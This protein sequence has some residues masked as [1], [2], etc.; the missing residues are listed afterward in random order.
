L[1]PKFK[2]A[3]QKLSSLPGNR[4]A[5]W[6]DRVRYV[7]PSLPFISPNV[8]PRV[9]ETVHEAILQQRQLQLRY[10]GPDDAGAR[11][12]TLHPLAFIQCGPIAYLVATAYGYTDPRLYAMHR[13]RS[14]QL[15]KEPS[16][17]PD[18][19]SL[20]G[21]LAEGGMQFGD[22][23]MIQLEAMVSNKLACYLAESPLTKDQELIPKGEGR[24]LLTAT[25]KDSWQLHFWI[26]SQSTEITVVRPEDLR[27][28]IRGNLQAALESYGP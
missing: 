8:E 9:L 23:S 3:R 7:P 27:K 17:R 15:T 5:Q 2:Q 21:F 6:T 1:E 22:A 10:S 26:L 28:Y 19:F 16:N 12:L 4:Y 14:V 13:I 20:D 18:G 25:I 24:Y 11:K